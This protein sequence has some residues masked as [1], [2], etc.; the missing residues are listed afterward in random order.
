MSQSEQ[1]SIQV[2]QLILSAFE[3]TL[4]KEQDALSQLDYKGIDSSTQQ[5]LE[6]QSQLEFALTNHGPTLEGMDPEQVEPLKSALE[7]CR[8]LAKNNESRILAYQEHIKQLQA[9]LSGTPST[10]Y[11]P[12]KRFMAAPS[13][14]QPV[15]TDS[16]G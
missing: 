8:K 11:G 2:L 6:L 13:C 9:R 10:G 1:S 7:E 14:S 16:V 12:R 5:K 4:K 15:L 3:Q